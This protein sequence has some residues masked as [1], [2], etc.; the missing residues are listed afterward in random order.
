MTIA[1]IIV[2]TAAI[3]FVV[4]RIVQEWNARRALDRRWRMFKTIQA[5]NDALFGRLEA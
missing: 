5:L 1:A 3:T 4:T 2:A